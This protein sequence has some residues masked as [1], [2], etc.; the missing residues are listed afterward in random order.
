V[1]SV[2]TQNRQNSSV[3]QKTLDTFVKEMQPLLLNLPNYRKNDKEMFKVK[4]HGIG[5]VSKQIGRE[6]F[7][8]QAQIME[9]AAKSETWSYVDAHMD[10]F[11]N[12]LCEVVEDA[13]KELTQLAPNGIEEQI[14]IIDSSNE[15]VT[16]ILKELLDAFDK[17]DLNAIE[18]ALEKLDKSEKNQEL[19][20]LY[21]TLR[22]AYDNLEYEEGTQ[23]LEE[24]LQ[25]K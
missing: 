24:Y 19:L 2:V 20:A 14:D 11:L 17:Y 15:D 8:E 9:M 16:D 1:V 21:G 22:E 4:V 13:T 5:G 7:A 23:I 12:A 3:Y 25:L 18:E 6:T 10:E